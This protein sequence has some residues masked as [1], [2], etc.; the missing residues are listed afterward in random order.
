MTS[1]KKAFLGGLLLVLQAGATIRFGYTIMLAMLLVTIFVIFYIDERY[2]RR[3][4]LG[5]PTPRE[6]SFIDEF[7]RRARKD[8]P[9]GD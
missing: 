8:P 6:Q 9:F 7:R 1:L 3:E 5:K 4:T 2:K